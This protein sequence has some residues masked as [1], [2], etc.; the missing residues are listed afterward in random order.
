MR[1]KEEV[2]QELGLDELPDDEF[3]DLLREA[4]EEEIV[5]GVSPVEEDGYT[6]EEIRDELSEAIVAKNVGEMISNIR[7]QAGIS[8]REA[9]E[10]I[11]V[12][13]SRIQQ[14]ENSDNIEIGTL[15]RVAVGLGFQVKI[16]LEPSEKNSGDYRSI[17]ADLTEAVDAG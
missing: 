6:P 11:G 10:A 17:E 2:Q 12:S 1:T 9:A 3:M 7:E 16:S 5:S 8:L 4:G 13:H 14:L 15:A